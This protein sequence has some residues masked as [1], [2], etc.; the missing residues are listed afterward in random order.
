VAL[1]TRPFRVAGTLFGFGRKIG[2]ACNVVMREQRAGERKDGPPQDDLG[3][4]DP[5][6][7][8]LGQDHPAR[9]H[10]LADN[11]PR[12]V[13]TQEDGVKPDGV[14]ARSRPVSRAEVER[15][16][17]PRVYR[18]EGATWCEVGIGSKR[19]D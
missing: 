2:R 1:P 17:P 14:A 8:D 15:A 10:R 7:G 5:W 11:R 12:D 4:D 18:L 9:H 13:R 16:H 3:R 6:Q 19:D